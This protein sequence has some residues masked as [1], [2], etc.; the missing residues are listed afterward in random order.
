MKASLANLSWKAILTG[1]VVDVASSM[2][3]GTAFAIY[4]VI[5]LGLVHAPKETLGPTL[6]RNLTLQVGGLLIGMAC[7]ILGGYV[8]GRLAS[9]SKATHGALSSYLCVLFGIYSLVS[10]MDSHT[11]WQ[12]ILLMIAGP[13]CSFFGGHLSIKRAQVVVA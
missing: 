8:A 9:H 5:K 4:M 6:Q 13:L 3:I 2:M 10:G 1:G 12:Q 11:W 7:S